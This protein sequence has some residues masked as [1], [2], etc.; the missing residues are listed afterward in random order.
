MNILIPIETCSREL[1]YKVYLCN[2]LAENGFTCYLGSKPQIIYLMKSLSNYIYLD[3]GYHEGVSDILYRVVKKNNGLIVSLDEEGGVDFSNHQTLMSRYSKPL[4]DSAN[5]IFLW[6]SKQ[7]K[8]ASTNISNFDNVKVSGHPRFELLKPEYQYLYSKEVDK[9]KIKY[10]S[11]ILINTNM[12]FG[13]NIKGDDFVK[14][15]YGGRFNNIEGLI[16]FDK[17]KL[18]SF[19]SL[20]IS[21]SQEIFSTVVI[22]PHPEE[23]LDY[24]INAFKGINSVKIVR[25]GSNGEVIFFFGRDFL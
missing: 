12:G 3:K 1:L 4:F 15:N 9:I 21:L 20:V 7:K 23:N 6:G 10:G 25:S 11:F 2:L 17:D 8:I 22:R 14:E 5:L 16:S 19:C 13:N 18:S 24:Y